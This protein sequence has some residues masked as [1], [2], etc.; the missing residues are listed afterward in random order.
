MTVELISV[1]T[2]I[3]LGNIVNTN[4]AYLARECANL[5]LSMYNQCVVGDN[6]ARL[7]QAYSEALKRSDIIILGGGL[8]PTEDD[9]TKETVCEVLGLELVEDAKA[10][11][12]ME[13]W[14][15]NLGHTPTVNN[16][17]QALVPSTTDKEG[18]IV[19]N[20]V[21]LYNNNG[22]APGIIIEKNGHYTIL[23]PGP[24]D[25]M[26]PMFEKSVKPYLAALSKDTIYSVTIRECGTG[27][28]NLETKLLD[29]IDAQTNPTIATYAKTGCCDIR[30]TARG[31]D[32]EDARD[33]VKPVVKEIKNR[34][35]TAIYSM[36]EKENIEDALVK[37]LK[38]YDLKISTA[39]SCTGGLVAAKL[40]NVNGASQVFTHGFITYS[41]KA[42]R[43][44]LSVN[45]DTLKKYS[46]V[47]KEVA[48]EMAKGC[49][50][51]ADSDVAIAVTGYAGPDDTKEE[52]KG[53]VYISCAV[54]DKVIAEKFKFNGTRAKIRESAA[55]KALNMAR[56]A[57]LAA[58]SN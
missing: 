35:K 30:V 50:I 3:L 32:E 13:Q 46:A 19:C 26:V 34:L 47:S 20:S 33:K 43:K 11:E 12:D 41:N 55:I 21:V 2:E 5:G 48:K 4:A 29:L 1:G 10:R 49:I 17:K 54:G 58:Y 40:V 24:P 44:V 14:L 8:G 52:P 15:T 36:D 38:K 25:E 31:V 37:L 45:R 51:T 42:K 27:E 7:A 57:I 23:L 53:L 9:L 6:T 22:T 56:L 39:E 18:Q 28:S 16:Y